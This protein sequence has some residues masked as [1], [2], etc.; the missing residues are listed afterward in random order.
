M[1]HDPSRSI[2]RHHAAQSQALRHGKCRAKTLVAQGRTSR[3]ETPATP[4]LSQSAQGMRSPNAKCGPLPTIRRSPASR[5]IRTSPALILHPARST[6][7]QSAADLHRDAIAFIE[8]RPRMSWV[9]DRRAAFHSEQARATRPLQSAFK[10]SNTTGAR[11]ASSR[12]WNWS[13]RLEQFL[14]RPTRQGRENG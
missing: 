5:H 1:R 13:M 3:F 4:M 7:Q 8:S 9:S 14:K 12:P 10:P 2:H 11:S 6:K